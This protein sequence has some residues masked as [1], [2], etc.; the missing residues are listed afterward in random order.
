MPSVKKSL[1]IYNVTNQYIMS[2]SAPLPLTIH[3]ITT[4]LFN[5]KQATL[6]SYLLEHYSPDYAME[7]LEFEAAVF[8]RLGSG[9]GNQLKIDSAEAIAS[10]VWLD[11][12]LAK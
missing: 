7:M 8:S 12:M 5:R 2:Y 1:Y 3:T 9:G 6:A 11:E 10:I 4:H